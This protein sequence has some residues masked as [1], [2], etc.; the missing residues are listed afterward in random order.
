MIISTFNNADNQLYV[1]VN[2]ISHP[3]DVTIGE[4][5][6]WVNWAPY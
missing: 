6:A 5:T 1:R 2:L 4:T 3:I